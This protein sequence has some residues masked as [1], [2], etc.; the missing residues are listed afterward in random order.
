MIR[1]YEKV[2]LIVPARRQESG[3]RD[4]DLRELHQLRFISR[5]RDLGFSIKEISKLLGLWNESEPLK[6][7]SKGAGTGKGGR[8]EEEGAGL[9]R[10]VSLA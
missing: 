10:D 4:Y 1:H 6:R 3:Y 2:A 8:D 5:A 7:R 9:G